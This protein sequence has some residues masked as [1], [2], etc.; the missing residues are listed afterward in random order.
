[1][2]TAEQLLGVRRRLRDSTLRAPAA[3]SPDQGGEESCA[4][5]AELRA[6]RE[7]ASHVTP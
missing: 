5:E 3:G 1:M 4:V 6:M 7:A 2:Q